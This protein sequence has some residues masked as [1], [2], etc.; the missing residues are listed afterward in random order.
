MGHTGGIQQ[1]RSLRRLLA[2]STC[3]TKAQGRLGAVG[4]L[5]TLASKFTFQASFRGVEANIMPCVSDNFPNRNIQHYNDSHGCSGLCPPRGA[6]PRCLS[7]NKD[8]CKV[9]PFLL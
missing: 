8:G 2:G 4:R 9:P 7:G 3:V 1:G 6:Q 5:M